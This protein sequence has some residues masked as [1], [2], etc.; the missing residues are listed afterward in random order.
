ML[1][2]ILKHV[3]WR[4][5]IYNLFHQTFKFCDFKKGYWSFSKSIIAH[6]FVIFKDFATQAIYCDSPDHVLQNDIQH[7]QIL[8]V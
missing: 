8:R 5:Q 6:I 4:L 2:I 3:I 1:Y 7:V